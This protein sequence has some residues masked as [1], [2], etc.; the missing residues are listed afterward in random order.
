M[1]RILMVGDV[2]GVA[3]RLGR[4]IDH[5]EGWEAIL[6]AAPGYGARAPRVIKAMLMPLRASHIAIRTWRACRL[7]RPDLV[8]LHWARLAPFIP[9]GSTPLVVH[10]HG[11]D[12]RPGLGNALTQRV[13][14]RAMRSAALRIAATPDLAR[15][16]MVDA[17]YLPNVVD[18]SEFAPEPTERSPTAPLTVFVFAR[19]SAIKGADRIL[20]ALERSTLASTCRVVAIESGAEFEPRARSLGVILLPSVSHHDLPP[21]LHEASVVIGQQRLGA[22]GLSELEAMACGRPVVAH[23]DSNLYDD[24]PPVRSTTDADALARELDLLLDRPHERATTG[25]AAR[26]WTVE[27]HSADAVRRSLLDL[28]RSVLAESPDVVR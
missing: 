25:E 14:Q 26:R 15:S 6:V 10:A 19:L 23:V 16:A 22:L 3:A 28:Y 17:H 8:H 4:L 13:V 12:V 27:H 11:T 5:E 9:H 1:P 24:P 21:L 2:A 7:H 18:T 20:D